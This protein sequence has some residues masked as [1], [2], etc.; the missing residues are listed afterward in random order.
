[1]LCLQIRAGRWSKIIRNSAFLTAIL[2][3]N[4]R[5]GPLICVVF[6]M[7]RLLCGAPCCGL[8]GRMIRRPLRCA[9]EALSRV[10]MGTGF[11]W[12]PSKFFF[13]FFNGGRDML[14]SQI[15][16]LISFK[17]GCVLST[18]PVKKTPI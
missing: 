6:E 17:L 14:E 1:M 2:G 7:P 9:C 16:M 5:A 15:K 3:R 11:H 13:C 4:C 10:S 18:V 12:K 8:S